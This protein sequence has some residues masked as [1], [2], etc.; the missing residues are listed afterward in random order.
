MNI[1]EVLN[2][3]KIENV[4]IS[5]IIESETANVWRGVDITDI[6]NSLRNDLI[7]HVAK[8]PD[9][10]VH[11]KLGDFVEE[12]PSFKKYLELLSK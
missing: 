5:H 2:K 3:W 11:M 8:Y 1:S 10:D 12:N 4:S 7:M 9:T 6:I